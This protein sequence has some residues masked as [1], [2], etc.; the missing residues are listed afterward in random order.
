[1]TARLA[2][3]LTLLMTLPGCALIFGAAAAVVVDEGIE[4]ERGGDGLF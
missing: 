3:C 4:Q 2:L 1:M